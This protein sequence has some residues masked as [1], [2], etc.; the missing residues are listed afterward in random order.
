M[1]NVIK[2]WVAAAVLM[3]VAGCRVD[4]SEEKYVNVVEEA[5]YV[6][7]VTGDRVLSPVLS[8]LD[9]ALKVDMYVKADQYGRYEL[10]DMYFPDYKVR[11]Y[12][13]KCVLADGLGE[14]VFDGNSILDEG[15]VW[16]CTFN[17]VVAA[18]SCT[19]PD[20]W[21][22]SVDLQTTRLDAPYSLN[23]METHVALADS[24]D[25]GYVYGVTVDGDYT[26]HTSSREGN[27]VV[28]VAFSTAEPTMAVLSHGP[29]F[30][31]FNG[32]FNLHMDISGGM[33]RSEDIEV[34]L[35]PAMSGTEVTV[36]YMGETEFWRE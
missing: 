13:D 15:A 1:K 27:T 34:R 6:Y 16:E 21:D 36:N 12:D 14:F 24:C 11:L 2:I 5:Y 32:G 7:C 28:E 29:L 10:E 18:V 22:V 25:Y 20:E 23:A 30:H 17:G 33:E 9:R 3:T 4:S 19:G 31:F 8:V 26:E 35:S